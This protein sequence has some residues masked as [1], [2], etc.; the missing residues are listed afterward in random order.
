[1]LY[2]LDSDRRECPS[3]RS[4]ERQDVVMFCFVFFCVCFHN[5]LALVYTQILTNLSNEANQNCVL[6]LNN[7]GTEARIFWMKIV[8]AGILYS[9][10][11]IIILFLVREEIG[12]IS[13]FKPVKY[14]YR[15]INP[16][17]SRIYSFYYLLVITSNS[18]SITISLWTYLIPKH[19]YSLQTRTLYMH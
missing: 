4:V 5:V 9:M 8:E 10:Y 1:M 16:W 13:K 2:A 3:C 6:I 19:N 7:I 18:M 17:K 14:S 11:C 12:T 15:N